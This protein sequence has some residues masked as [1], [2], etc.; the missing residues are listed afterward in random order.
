ME[1]EFA[2]EDRNLASML[3]IVRS[4]GKNLEGHHVFTEQEIERER[5][6]LKMLDEYYLHLEDLMRRV[7]S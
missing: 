1:K 7:R 3:R 5:K 4:L 2:T 6:R